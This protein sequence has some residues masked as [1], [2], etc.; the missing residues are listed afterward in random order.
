VRALESEHSLL[1]YEANRQ[2]WLTAPAVAAE[3]EFA[4]MHAAGVSFFDGT[5]CTPQYPAAALAL[6]GGQLPD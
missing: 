2:G 6:P 5:A 4:A 3:P 1:A